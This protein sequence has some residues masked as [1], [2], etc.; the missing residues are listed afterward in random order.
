MKEEEKIS[1]QEASEDV[2]VE[3]VEL[4]GS[5]KRLKDR[6]PEENPADEDAWDGLY[7][8][9]MDENEAEI[10][11]YK[12]AEGRMAELCSI[13]PEFAELVYNMLE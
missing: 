1:G 5:R 4:K 2:S 10:G 7:N 6:Y 11:K 8:R 12:N 13:Y 9:Y 3:P